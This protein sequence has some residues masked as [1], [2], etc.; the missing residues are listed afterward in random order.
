MPRT[1]WRVG[2]IRSGRAMGNV[3]CPGPPCH[4]HLTQQT[5]ILFS[6]TIVVYVPFL[7]SPKFS[8]LQVSPPGPAVHWGCQCSCLHL[9][10]VI[11][12]VGSLSLAFW[13]F[14]TCFGFRR[15][16]HTWACLSKKPLPAHLI[17]QFPDFT[18]D[19][20]FPSHAIG[21]LFICLQVLQ[22]PK[23]ILSNGHTILLP[24]SPVTILVTSNLPSLWDWLFVGLAPHLKVIY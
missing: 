12:E 10:D 3:H 24:K 20:F 1:G 14:P 15:R 21:R 5:H 11:L 19:V 18:W 16:K 7:F 6:C 2:N 17:F 23:V 9:G 8:L 4:C 13:V 22:S